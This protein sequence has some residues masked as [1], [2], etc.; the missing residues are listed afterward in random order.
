MLKISTQRSR[1]PS[2]LFFRERTRPNLA[3][4]SHLQK[5]DSSKQVVQIPLSL[6]PRRM[7]HPWALFRQFNKVGKQLHPSQCVRQGTHHVSKRRIPLTYIHNMDTRQYNKRLHCIPLIKEALLSSAQ[8]ALVR[9]ALLQLN[10]VGFH[11]DSDAS[12][13]G[14]FHPKLTQSCAAPTLFSLCYT[15]LFHTS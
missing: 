11:S 9:G 3:I 14:V 15:S 6:A 2:A 4:P 10:K 12:Q 5:M 1:T 8:T 7:M 13:R